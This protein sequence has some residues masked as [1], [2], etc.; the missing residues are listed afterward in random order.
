MGEPVEGGQEVTS[1]IE[2]N[3]DDMT[4]EAL[5]F[6]MERLFE[7]GALDVYFTPIQMKKNRPAVMLSVIAPVAQERELAAAILKETT[8]LGVRISRTSR[9]TAARRVETVNTPFGDVR[10]KVKQF[11]GREHCSPE[12]DDC[13]RVAREQG[14]PLVEVVQA[15]LDACSRRA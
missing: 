13:A 12:Y 15:A 4:P 1:L 7:A 3:L 2:A 5:G 8:T 10:V 11:D 9:F 14:L 6:A